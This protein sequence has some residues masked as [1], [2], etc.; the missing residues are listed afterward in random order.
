MS[1]Q[2][3]AIILY[4]VREPAKEDLLGTLKRVRDIGF[5]YV[6]WSGMPPLPADEI[7]K[8]LDAAGLQAIAAHTSMEP[9]EEDIEAQIAFWNTVGTKD[10]APGGMMGDCRDTLEGWL[11]GARRLEAIGAKLREAG[12]R[13]SYHNHAWEVEEKFPGDDRPKLDVLYGET[14][15]Q[16][17]YA[18]LDLGW[19][20]AGGGDPAAYLRKYAGRCPVVH[21]KD[22][23]PAPKEGES[24][25]AELGRGALDWDAIFAAG[26][27]A[28]VEWYVYEQ[29]SCDGDVWD[30]VQASYEFL[31]A[32]V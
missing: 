1:D 29:D 32:N 28:G 10:V 14:G 20:H 3:F 26:S 25:F 21:A 11:N 24:R 23:K 19:V 8:A 6:Q 22:M 2:G 4:T 17:L 12:M 15:A 18:E 30:S 31:K 7:R 27:E 5:E 13:L 9:F 16:N